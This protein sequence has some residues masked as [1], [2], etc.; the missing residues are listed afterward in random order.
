MEFITRRTA[1]NTVPGGLTRGV[2]RGSGRGARGRDSGAAAGHLVAVLDQ[3][4][5]WREVAAFFLP[6]LY[7][8][9]RSLGRNGEGA[10]AIQL[11]AVRHVPRVVALLGQTLIP[12]RSL[13]VCHWR[14]KKKRS[15]SKDGWK[16]LAF[17]SSASRTR[18]ASYAEKKRNFRSLDFR[19]FETVSSSD[20]RM[21]RETEAAKGDFRSPVASKER[22]I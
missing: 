5:K 11:V 7:E 20:G 8:T 16:K 3:L 6:A 2:G 10:Q 1:T 13:V 14:K 4:H 18:G 12:A 15:A 21:R 19:P 17:L 22:G 9:H